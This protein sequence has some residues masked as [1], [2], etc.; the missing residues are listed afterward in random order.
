VAGALGLHVVAEGVES[1]G[2]GEHLRQL[3]CGLMQGYFFGR[4][5]P[6]AEAQTLLSRPQ[7]ILS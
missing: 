5:M 6:A 7:P 4:P 3:G 1:A 2:Q